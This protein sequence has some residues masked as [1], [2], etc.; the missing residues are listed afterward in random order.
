MK[1]LIASLAG[2]GI[3]VV[4]AG[5]IAEEADQSVTDLIEEMIVTAT[6]REESIQDVPIAVSAFSGEDLS[7]RGVHD[8]YGLMEV[9]PSIA[10]YSSNS[11]S[12]GGTLRIRGVGTT[13]NN[14]GLEAAVGTF[15]DG[16]Y[17]SRAGLAF[18]DLIDIDRVEILRG[19]QGTLFGKNT[20]AGAVNIVTRKPE[21]ENN[22]S[23]TV[24]VGNLDSQEYGFVGNMV[25]ADDV[26]AGRIAYSHRKRDGFYN[27]VDSGEAYDNR[28]RHNIRGQLLWTP[29]D[30]VEARLI[31]DYTEK[32]ES[33]CPA[34]FWING[35]SSPVVAIL[36]GD[37]APFEV[38]ND[39]RVGVNYEPYE[40]V[41]EWG[42]SLD[43]LWEVGDSMNFR[44]I[45]A[46][47]DYEVSRGQ[48]IDFTS[49]D[50]LHP[51]DTDETFENF[52]Q[53]FQLY[54][55]NG[56]L[57]WLVGGYA[58]TEDMDSTEQI[59]LSH[60]GGN[61]IGFLFRNPAVAPLFM[62]DPAGRGVPGQGYDAL[63]FSE[64]K[65]W[66]LFT[67]NTWHA[68]D[69]FDITAGARYSWEK[70]DAGAIING[71]P[72]GE[73][74]NDP[75]CNFFGHIS[76]FFSLC[77]NLSYNNSESENKLT[78][79]LKLAWQ[80]TDD[81]NLYTSYSRGYKAGGYNLDQEAVGNRDANGNFVDQSRFDPETSD[82]F[83]IGMKGRFFDQRF[84]VNSALFYTV[85]DDFQLNTFTGL[86]FTV[87]N[88]KK[89]VSSGVELESFLTLGEGVFLTMGATYTDARY[90]DEL[91]P[92]NAHLADKRLTQ[93]PLW[94]ASGSIFLDREIP[95]TNFRWVANAN[96]SHIGEV[97]TG[98]DLD[99]PQKVRDAFNVFN[100]QIG[101]KTADGR[102]E[103]T[104][105]GRNLSDKQVNMLVFDSVFQSGS[106]HTFVNEPRT[107]GI[108]LKASLN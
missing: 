23:M 36:G 72:Y 62:G 7:A 68:S 91:A 108:T 74:I 48:D 63:F 104:A 51:Q 99:H 32:D 22:A 56:S 82:S 15:I 97:N 94:Q 83:E 84:T 30:R 26:L 73:A 42:V 28:D 54:G 95:N 81:V 10:V 53:E 18:N 43:V 49:A 38:D 14:P 67:H 64:A 41:E 5:V 77:D 70:K 33:C 60:D 34:A 13:G 101:I 20:V 65:G 69:V 12:N 80:V 57:S 8:I 87:G 58:Y 55:E 39:A 85:F 61:Y 90:D 11:T 16:I 35:P 25:I 3:L 107:Y 27:D 46:Y 24:G 31:A 2:L 9:A 78:G 66:S 105:W 98:S 102:Y 100:A 103:I 21:F 86:G 47:R 96:W 50:I 88:V 71:A 79:T 106:W 40:D 45:T 4:P 59:V 29:N 19:P 1:K 37:I 44:S 89:V 92:G 76:A 6:K 93:S 75:F 52:S 17:R